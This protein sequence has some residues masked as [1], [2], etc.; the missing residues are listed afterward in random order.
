VP[1]HSGRRSGGQAPMKRFSVR[2]LVFQYLTVILLCG[3]QTTLW[4]AIFGHIQSPQFWLPWILFLALYRGYFE[5]VFVAYFYGLIMLAFSSL[6]L[7]LV[8]PSF[9]AL[10]S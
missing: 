10:V 5:A 7:Q 4:P 3:V 2:I 8:W 1:V 9:L 6:S